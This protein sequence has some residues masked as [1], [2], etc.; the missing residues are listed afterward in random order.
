MSLAP[1]THVDAY[2]VVGPLGKGGM[3]EVYRALETGIVRNGA[4][5]ILPALFTSDADRV[6]R[7]D[8]EARV[9]A[10]L[11]HPGIAVSKNLGDIVMFDGLV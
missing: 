8:R 10:S 6:A 5:K 2:R 3:G 4:T 11:N 1:G 7:F 9:L